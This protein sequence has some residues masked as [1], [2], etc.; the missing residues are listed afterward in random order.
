M[1]MNLLA[2]PQHPGLTPAGWTLLIFCVGMVIGLLTFCYYMLL[3]EPNPSERHHGPLDIDT[4]DT[5]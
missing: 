1:M 4:Q 5:G 2:T 3:R